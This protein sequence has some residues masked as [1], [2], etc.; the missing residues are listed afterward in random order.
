MTRPY[1]GDTKEAKDV[2]LQIVKKLREGENCLHELSTKQNHISLPQLDEI[3]ECLRRLLEKS[4]VPHAYLL[5]VDLFE[6]RRHVQNN[7]YNHVK[8][9]YSQVFE[10]P[11]KSTTD[12]LSVLAMIQEE[13]GH[14]HMK[15]LKWDKAYE[16]FLKSF[17]SYQDYSSQ[18]YNKQKKC[19]LVQMIMANIL[20][21]LNKD[22]FK[23]NGAHLFKDDE[24]V[25]W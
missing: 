24:D 17:H 8:E 3:L 2:N 23:E 13:C 7:S 15:Y 14:M 16:V 22:P 12:N 25:M 9:L 19:V 20:G 1:Q 6:I 10:R 21:D 5:D 18:D 11:N 4:K